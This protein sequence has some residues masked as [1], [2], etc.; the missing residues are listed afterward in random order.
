[1]FCIFPGA[2]EKADLQK[3]IVRLMKE[4]E[5]IIFIGC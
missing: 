1:M 2:S 3:E 4:N 5:G